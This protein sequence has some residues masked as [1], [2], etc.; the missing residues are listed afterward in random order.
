MDL[1]DMQLWLDQ[2]RQS[3]TTT[4]VSNDVPADIKQPRIDYL[5]ARIAELTQQKEREVKRFDAA[6][7][8][9]NGELAGL[10]GKTPP[11]Q[12]TSPPSA[13]AVTEQPKAKPKT[14]AKK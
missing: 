11:D 1:N 12:G 14:K 13:E 10:T 2:A 9:L 5:K 3:L 4:K 6:I 8:E 7:A